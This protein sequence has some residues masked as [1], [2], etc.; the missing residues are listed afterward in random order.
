MVKTSKPDQNMNIQHISHKMSL[1][2]SLSGMARVCVH[3]DST[4]PGEP[5]EEGE[6]NAWI[7]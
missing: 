7:H 5:P 3:T 6:M 1:T 2:Y 4:G